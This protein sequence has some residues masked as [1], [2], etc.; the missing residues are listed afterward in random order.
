MDF[1]NP[2]PSS[3]KLL[4]LSDI[5]VESVTNLAEN[6]IRSEEY[7]YDAIIVCG[8]FNQTTID[9]FKKKNSKTNNDVMKDFTSEQ[10]G[11]LVGELSTALAQLENIV[12][13]VIY[14]SSEVDPKCILNEQMH[15]TPNSVN[16]NK[17][18]LPLVKGLNLS[19]ITEVEESISVE[20]T[21][22]DSADA[23]RPQSMDEE[24]GSIEY[25]SSKTNNEIEELLKKVSGD[26]KNKVKEETVEEE[27]DDGNMITIT[28]PIESTDIVTP[29]RNDDMIFILNYKYM[30]TL[31][32]FI[33]H[34][35]EL[36]VRA[37]VNI[38]ILPQAN[39]ITSRL[40]NKVLNGIT[41]VVIDSLRKEG[42]FTQIK[43]D[44]NDEDGTW[45]LNENKSLSVKELFK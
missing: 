25:E 15:L 30:H 43:L 42:K 37:G 11:I 6:M 1:L 16:I 32:K 39:D 13:R 34:R 18:H 7:Q 21:I 29:K 36:L 40:D 12:C 22:M 23:D 20:D 8:P 24:T 17:R 9:V 14:L 26:D 10:E 33:F 27:D 4:L 28:R 2:I 41:F 38:C 45:K 35:P 44:R 3:L 5:D 19:G 31:N